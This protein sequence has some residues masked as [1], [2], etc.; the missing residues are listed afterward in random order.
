MK[1]LIIFLPTYKPISVVVVVFFFFQFLILY[2]SFFNEA[3]N[4]FQYKNNP[5]I[6]FAGA[7]ANQPPVSHQC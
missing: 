7:Y 6:L 3:C 5:F 4:P 2:F 1:V